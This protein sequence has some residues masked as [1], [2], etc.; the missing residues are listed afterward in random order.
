MWN[1]ILQHNCNTNAHVYEWSLDDYKKEENGIQVQEMIYLIR[2]ELD[3]Y[4]HNEKKI[5]EYR[6]RW[7]GRGHH[8]LVHWKKIY[9]TP[10]ENVVSV[11][12]F[13]LIL[14]WSKE[15][16]AWWQSIRNNL[17]INHTCPPVL[18]RPYCL[19]SMKP[20]S[21]SVLTILSSKRVPLIYLHN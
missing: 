12:G 15:K 13:C 14:T 5:R 10:K 6:K 9:R 4:N 17:C 21:Q 19:P 11:T 8:T 7:N 18:P 16:T 3:I 20:A 1:I 2:E